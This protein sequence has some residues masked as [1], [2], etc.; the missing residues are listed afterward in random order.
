MLTPEPTP[1]VCDVGQHYQQFKAGCYLFVNQPMTWTNASA[2]CSKKSAA[3]ASI[4]SPYE[5]AFIYVMV[6]QQHKMIPAIWI[7]LN[8]QKVNLKC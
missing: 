7:G 6:K 8:D 4:N 1:N 5:Q 3:L 2:S